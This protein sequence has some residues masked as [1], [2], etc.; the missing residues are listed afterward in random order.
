M[1][2]PL[3]DPPLR[4]PPLHNPC[5]QALPPRLP[6]FPPTGSINGQRSMPRGLD[7]V[8]AHH[9]P[10]HDPLARAGTGAVVVLSGS[11]GMLAEEGLR[12]SR[13]RWR[14]VLLSQGRFW[15]SELRL[16]LWWWWRMWMTVL[17]S[18]FGH[19]ALRGALL[20]WVV[21]C[22]EDFGDAADPV[23]VHVMEG[24]VDEGR[25]A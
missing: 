8:I 16:L 7:S 22:G 14:V 10:G 23:S 21:R 5:Q 6:R 24:S 2:P 3:R 4:R 12:G 18:R 20:G 9:P 17:W 13:W 19:Q 25:I 15:R 1:P 11:C